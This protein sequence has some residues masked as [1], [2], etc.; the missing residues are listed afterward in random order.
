MMGRKE[1]EESKASAHS[2]FYFNSLAFPSFLPS[3]H[4]WSSSSSSIRINRL[5]V[6]LVLLQL[7]LFF[8]LHPSG[9]DMK[10]LSNNL[11]FN[12][13]IMLRRSRL[14]PCF[15]LSFFLLHEEGLAWPGLGLAWLIF[16]KPNT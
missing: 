3:F 16:L 1:E 2:G 6:S 5:Q 10:K 9:M 8:R 11:F 13:V 4:P 14:T 7:Q 15:F 12:V